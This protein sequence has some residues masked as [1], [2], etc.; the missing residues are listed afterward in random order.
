MTNSNEA[1]RLADSASRLLDEPAFAAALSAIRKDIVSQI[2]DCPVRDKE[3]AILLMQLLK[4]SRKYES[5][6]RGYI[7]TGKLEKIKLSDN[8][9][10]GKV[11]QFINRF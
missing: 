4:L 2:E 10:E 8:R 6:L 9:T 3:G 1:M 11:R 7:E 5:V